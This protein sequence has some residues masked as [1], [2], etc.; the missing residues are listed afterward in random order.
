MF[1]EQDRFLSNQQ[2]GVDIADVLYC[3]REDKI[4]KKSVH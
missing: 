4:E 1:N 3:S 2:W